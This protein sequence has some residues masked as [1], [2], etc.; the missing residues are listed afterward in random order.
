MD[1]AIIIYGPTAVG[2]TAFAEPL[3]CELGGEIINA[4]VAQFYTP[5]TIGTAKPDWHNG[6]VPHHLFDIGD[7]PIDYSVASYR[8]DAQ[9]CVEDITRRGK[10]PIFV[11]GS[12]FYIH[13]LLFPVGAMPHEQVP[14]PDN[15]SWEDLHAIDPVRAVAIHPH[16]RYRINRALTLYQQTKELP[17]ALLPAYRP[18]TQ[19]FLV[20]L[21]CEPEPLKNRIVARTAQMLDTGW[22][23][24]A[25]SLIG[26]SWEQFVLRKKW[27]GYP[28]LIAYCK[29]G[30]PPAEFAVVKDAIIRHT[31]RYARK[32]M[33]YGRMLAKKITAADPHALYRKINLTSHSLELYIK[34]LI[35]D[36]VSLPKGFSN[37]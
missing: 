37:E 32:Q 4:D 9:R 15:L 14:A 2:K 7:S 36:I 17:S 25:E 30:K 28:E 16:D 29:A 18:I 20:E 31:W 22:L 6:A 8:T 27:I 19:I 24:E 12:G 21:S 10:I 26:T 5:L 1:R 3:A 33:A 35:E 13:S 34:Q 11:G 23:A